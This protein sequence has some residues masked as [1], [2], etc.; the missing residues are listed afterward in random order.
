[1]SLLRELIK[2]LRAQASASTAPVDH[3]FYIRPDCSPCCEWHEERAFRPQ[4]TSQARNDHSDDPSW[5][6]EKARY[7]E[8]RFSPRLR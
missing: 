7:L 3:A 1:M 6:V 8:E 4:E 2:E 5:S